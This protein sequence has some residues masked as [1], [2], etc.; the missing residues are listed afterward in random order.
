RQGQPFDKRVLEKI[1]TFRA[2][3]PEVTLQVDGGVSIENAKELLN[4]GVSNLVVGSAI[5][6]AK[7]P[8]AVIAKFE[9]LQ[10]PFGV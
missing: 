4:L 8:S 10:T 9:S 1:K 5:V 6:R 3:H 7:N 2:Q